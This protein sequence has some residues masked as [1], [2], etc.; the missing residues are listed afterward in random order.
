VVKQAVERK[1]LQSFR[2]T[3]IHQVISLP[4]SRKKGN[5]TPPH[6]SNPPNSSNHAIRN[7]LHWETLYNDSHYPFDHKGMSPLPSI[8]NSEFVVTNSTVHIEDCTQK[9]IARA[10]INPNN[11]PKTKKKLNQGYSTFFKKD[12]EMLCLLEVD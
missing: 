1:I 7:D 11:T 4:A 3:S 6:L 9:R 10:K 2:I 12:E 8:T 5:Y